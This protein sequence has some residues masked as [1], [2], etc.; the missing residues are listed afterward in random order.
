MAGR[1][2]SIEQMIR[3]LSQAR[4]KQWIQLLGNPTFA[5]SARK[6]AG[7]TALHPKLGRDD[8]DLRT[9]LIHGGRT[10]KNVTAFP[11]G[12]SGAGQGLF[13]ETFRVEEKPRTH[14]SPPY[15]FF[16][17][18]F[19]FFFFVNL[20]KQRSKEATKT[21]RKLP[22]ESRDTFFRE[23]RA[24]GEADVFSYSAMLAM[25]PNSAQAEKAMAE[26]EAPN[27]AEKVMA[28]MQAAGIAPNTVT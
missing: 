14:E 5:S 13:Q 22:P 3:S 6:P 23:L 17:F 26:M 19:F 7:S 27:T 10:G 8:E 15:S 9:D 18:F 1:A 20:F 16:F 24:R 12:A 21:L 2:P 11:Q 28:E 4:G 25:S